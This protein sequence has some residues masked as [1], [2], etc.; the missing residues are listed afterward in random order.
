METEPVDVMRKQNDG[1]LIWI[2]AAQ[3]VEIAK[4]R[5]NTFARTAPGEYVIFDQ[6][7]QQVVACVV[8]SSEK[9]KGASAS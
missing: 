5:I 1:S 3:S 7:T 9:A 6:T 4:S 2:E 8:T